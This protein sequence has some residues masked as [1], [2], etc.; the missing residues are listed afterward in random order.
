MISTNIQ[1]FNNNNYYQDEF[2]KSVS[3]C[4]FNNQKIMVRT[5][6]FF[7]IY[8]GIWT[9]LDLSIP[10]SLPSVGIAKYVICD[11][12]RSLR[13]CGSVFIWYRAIC[14]QGNSMIGVLQSYARKNKLLIKP[15][16]VKCPN[17]GN[18]FRC[19]Q[20]MWTETRQLHS[21]R[22]RKFAIKHGYHL[23]L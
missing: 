5:C 16:A 14:L 12:C 3:L 22:W 15:G 10:L 2:S 11:R 8:F 20:N 6:Y 19:H 21:N 18:I 13:Y 4:Y 7:Q 1:L 17:E 9:F 23:V